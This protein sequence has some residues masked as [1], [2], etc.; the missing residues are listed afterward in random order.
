MRKKIL[1]VKQHRKQ[2]PAICIINV[3]IE[4]YVK[5]ESMNSYLFLHKQMIK[6]NFSFLTIKCRLKGFLIYGL[7][8]VK[9]NF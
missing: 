2:Y 8:E 5:K 4:K 7:S 1:G 6:K 3:K 9:D